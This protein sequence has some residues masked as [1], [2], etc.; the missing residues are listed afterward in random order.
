MI[1]D[2]WIYINLFVFDCGFARSKTQATAKPDGVFEVPKRRNFST[3][4]H[5]SPRE[6]ALSSRAS[7]APER[8]VSKRLKAWCDRDAKET[9]WNL[10]KCMIH[11]NSHTCQVRL[12]IWGVPEKVIP[13]NETAVIHLTS[14]IQPITSV[15]SIPIQYSQPSPVA[16]TKPVSRFLPDPTPSHGSSR[17]SSFC[18]SSKP[19]RVS[20][21]LRDL[22]CHTTQMET[23]WKLI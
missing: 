11:Q 2:E 18:S 22:S 12:F 3:F 13:Q 17:I 6:S 9:T 4:R 5:H 1:L 23:P 14:W 15:H 16:N 10:D 8:S 21:F 20:N 19:C 7:M